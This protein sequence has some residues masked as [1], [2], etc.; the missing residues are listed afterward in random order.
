M[1]YNP[2]LRVAVGDEVEAGQE[3]TEDPI[4]RKSSLRVKGVEGVQNYLLR[5][6]QRVYRMQGMEI[7]DKHIEV[8]VR[9]MLRKVK[10][11]ESAD[12]DVLPD[13]WWNCTV[14]EEINNEVL[15]RA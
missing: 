14:S 15:K 3:L 10:I 4:N 12:T 13:R 7:G 9:Q 6:V 8:M 5:E 2:R 11:L 1:P